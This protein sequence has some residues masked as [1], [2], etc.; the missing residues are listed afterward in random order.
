MRKY[1]PKFHDGMVLDEADMKEFM[2]REQ[3]IAFVD[4]DEDCELDVRFKSFTV[5][6]GVRKIFVSNPPP[7]NLYPVDNAGAIA[8][9]MTYMYIG[10]PTWQQQPP[11]APAPQPQPQ[12][13]P[14]QPL[15]RLSPGMPAQ[16]IFSP[17]TQRIV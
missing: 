17:A 12:P 16:P 1:D 15:A 2:S 11:R 10:W 9:R 6:A 4:T 7:Q 3:V 8:R 14:G 5:P 13:V